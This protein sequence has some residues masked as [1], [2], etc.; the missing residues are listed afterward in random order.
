MPGIEEDHLEFYSESKHIVVIC[1][2]HFFKLAVYRKNGKVLTP[3]ELQTQLQRIH[4][5]VETLAKSPLN[6]AALTSQRRDLWAKV[7]RRIVS[8]CWS[9][10]LCRS[11]AAISLPWTRR[12][13]SR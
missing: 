1:H 10:V 12:M 3:V 6:I 13:H 9:N 5:T 11:N 7:G 8:G 4:D 2:G